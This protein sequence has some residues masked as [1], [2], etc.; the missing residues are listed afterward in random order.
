MIQD[1]QQPLFEDIP[2]DNPD[3]EKKDLEPQNCL[4]TI[5]LELIEER[6]VQLVDIQKATK[7][8]WGTLMGWH[9][10]AVEC[11][12]LDRNIL[13]LAQYFNVHIHYLGF[14]IGDDSPVFENEKESQ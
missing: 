13:K 4:Q 5:L 1:N 6:K 11:Q 12:K 10:G 3:A 9:N 14:G 7:I 2:Q 8:P